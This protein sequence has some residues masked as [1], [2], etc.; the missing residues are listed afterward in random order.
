MPWA[1]L[2]LLAASVVAGCE[3]D[4]AAT[5]VTPPTVV[6]APATGIT[7]ATATAG[8]E[9]TADGGD[10]VTARGVV[11]SIESSPTFSSPH[12]ID[13]NGIGAFVS[14]ITGL[15][16]G[17][18]YYVRAYAVNSAGAAYGEEI[19]FTTVAGEYVVRVLGKAE[20]YPTLGNSLNEKCQVAGSY[21]RGDNRFSPFI[22]AP[23]TGFRTINVP[24][25]GSAF[26]INGG[27]TVVGVVTTDGA[28]R[29]YTWS[30][31]GGVRLYL[32]PAGPDGVNLT[33]S[34][35]A[36]INS[37]GVIA[38][39]GA[40]TDFQSATVWRQDSEPIVLRA[41]PLG[42]S[43]SSYWAN[44]INDAGVVVGQEGARPAVWSASGEDPERLAGNLVGRAW[45][46]NNRGDVVGVVGPSISALNEAMLWRDSQPVRLMALPG[47]EA[48]TVRSVTD[49]DDHG[50]IRAV[51]W[52]EPVLWRSMLERRPV[53]WTVDPSGVHVAELYPPTGHPSAIAKEI[54]IVNGELVIIGTSYTQ[55]SAYAV[56]WST[57]RDVCAF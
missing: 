52:S 11:W 5:A 44:A 29:A 1:L 47:H 48:A 30:E 43:L 7:P 42:S 20:G 32:P 50:V 54:K 27:G 6:T 41:H 34:F 26:A 39:H 25:D 57:S 21:H 46:L 45:G 31:A 56:M 16:P 18:T 28:D 14:E 10:R 40:R 15:D 37:H 53:I 23:D 49:P 22:W 13:G 55:D 2:I 3:K 12:T 4:P 8:G 33:S 19:S 36:A 17:V 24:G 51:G 9:V 38:G 35:G